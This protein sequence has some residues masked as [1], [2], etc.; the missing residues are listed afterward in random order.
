M[1]N[2]RIRRRVRRIT[3]GVVWLLGLSAA[4]CGPPERKDVLP[5]IEIRDG[6]EIA[7]LSHIPGPLDPDY[8]WK[9]EVLREIETVGAD[10][11]ADPLV[12]NPMGAVPLRNGNLLVYDPHA[13]RPLVILDLESGSALVRFGRN[14]QGPGELSERITLSEAADG[15]IVVLDILN[16]QIHS[17]SAA[18]T[19]L[20]SRRLEADGFPL[21]TAAWQEAQAF[22]LELFRQTGQAV[23]Y[24][25]ESVDFD[26]G[27]VLPFIEL[28]EPPP[29]W[30]LGYPQPGSA[31]WTGLK[32]GL[33]VMRSDQPL[34]RVYD[35]DAALIREI[36]L[37]LSHRT[38]TQADVR[39]QIAQHGDIARAL[40]KTGPISLTNVLTTVNDTVFG[41]LLSDLR[42]A[43]EDP[44]LPPGRMLWRMFTIR[45]AYV[46]VMW[47]PDDFSIL[48]SGGGAV[49]ARALDESGNPVIQE[50]RLVRAEAR[51]D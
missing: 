4:S 34:V 26:S 25:L 33:V 21:R 5:S 41:M 43:R 51:P 50:V 38:I 32:H 22:Q 13:D 17:Y 48:W 9:W 45:G 7:T 27:P 30:R 28:P 23:T 20:G 42:R 10:P 44:R 24:E 1:A 37:P 29:G 36:R 6:V 11:T 19:S 12:F 49:W 39:D 8:F 40:L 2:P 16:R 18:G 14:G 46:G 3:T 35:K 47:R 31:L 15:N